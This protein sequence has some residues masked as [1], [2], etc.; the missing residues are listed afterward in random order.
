MGRMAAG[1]AGAS[2][3]PSVKRFDSI[4]RHEQRELAAPPYPRRGILSLTYV[5][6]F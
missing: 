1:L 3:D 4:C 5:A 6:V 2:L